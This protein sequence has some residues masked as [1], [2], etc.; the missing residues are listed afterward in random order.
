MDSDLIEKVQCNFISRVCSMCNIGKYSNYDER[1]KLFN[2][3]PL[4]ER[5]IIG[6][7]SEVYKTVKGY[8]NCYLVDFIPYV[9]FE[10][11]HMVLNFFIY[12]YKIV[13]SIS[14]LIEYFTYGAVY[15]M[16]LILILPNF[17]VIESLACML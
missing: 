17:S 9:N 10:N 3:E 2:L 14:F 13:K 11:T 7:I 12:L 15:L 8:T 5:R 16:F 1:L 6:Y 4:Y